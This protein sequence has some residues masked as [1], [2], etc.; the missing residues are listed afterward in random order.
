MYGYRPEPET[1]DAKRNR[2]Q[3]KKK[4]RDPAVQTPRLKRFDMQMSSVWRSVGN[5]RD[6]RVRNT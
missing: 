4:A 1:H 6:A 3:G 5:S 2:L